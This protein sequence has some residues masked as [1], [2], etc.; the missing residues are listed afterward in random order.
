[1][2]NLLLNRR[3]I[4]SALGVGFL[5]SCTSG[6]DLEPQKYPL[7]GSV[8]RLSSELDEILDSNL[9]LELLKDG[10]SWS[11]G[12]AWDA[13]RQ[14]LYFSDVP[15]NT[16]YIWSEEKG[17]EI[18]RKP[19]GLPEGGD[20]TNGLLMARDGRLLTANHGKRALTKVD[21]DSGEDIILADRFEG[22]KFNSPND[23]IE[24]K[25][26]TLYFTDPPYGLKDGDESPLKE[27]SI[28]GVYR[29]GTDRIISLIDD[30]LT[31]PN[32]I[33]LSPDEKTLYVAQS[34]PE[35][36]ILKHYTIGDDGNISDK[37]LFFDANPLAGDDA[38][39]LPDG[40][41]VA[42]TGHIFATGPGGV[43]ILSPEGKLLGRILAE[44][45]TA[46][47]GFGDDGK[48]LYITSSDRL[49]RIRL[50]VKGLGVYS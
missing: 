20:G 44:K 6:K 36:Q 19:S 43:L 14:R 37:G 5:W 17:L 47:C 39:G 4:V 30:S 28:N 11:E 29:L 13:K 27:L 32:G 15:E 2:Q 34:D 26:G 31:R 38:P 10:F 16:A 49:A 23:V 22:K 21:I 9:Q 35:S 45:A 1:M 48:T 42:Q 18:F 12:P 25:D 3:S 8:E 24:A 41:C 46:N 33:V 40:M 50:K 7:F